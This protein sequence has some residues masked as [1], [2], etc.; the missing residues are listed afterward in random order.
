MY[1]HFVPVAWPLLAALLLIA[2]GKTAI[3]AEDAAS[4]PPMIKRP[5]MQYTADD[6]Q[7]IRQ[8][9][10]NDPAAQR[11][12][13]RTLSLSDRRGRPPQVTMFDLL[14][15]PEGADSRAAL[16]QDLRQRIGHKPEPLTWD[17]DPSTLE[18]NEG[19]PSAGDR[20]MRDERSE[21]AFLFDA[22]YDDLSAEERAG[23]EAYFRS[24]IQFHLDGHPPRHPHFQYDRTSWLPNMHWPRP[25]G[26]HLLALALQDEEAIRAM[27]HAEGGWKW[28]FDAYLVD[29]GFY[30]EE[31]G[32]QYS[33]TGSMIAW[34]EGLERLGLGEMGYDYV[35]ATG[36]SMRSHLKA[37]TQD[38]AFPATYW[39][40]G[41][42][43][44]YAR[45]TMGDAKGSGIV[46]HVVQHAVIAG[47]LADGTGGNR[48]VSAA[49][50]NGPVVKLREPYWFEA[51]HARWPE[52][53]Y[54]FFMAALRKPNE[55]MYYPSLL[56]NLD[57]I[58]P[59]TVTPPQPTPSYI[60]H[61]R[62]FA[63]LRADHS[64][65]YW[66]GPKPAVAL[67]FARYYVHYVHDCM[68]ILGFHAFNTPLIV[69]S[70]GI[71]R[72]YA[73]G[74]AWRDSVRGHSGIVVD[75]LQAQPVAR[76]FDGTQGHRYRSDFD[77]A[78]DIRFTAVR[79][80]GVYPGVAHER[81]LVLAQHYLLDV[82]WLK[83]EDPEVDRSFEWQVLSP[84]SAQISDA[85]TATD[86]LAEGALYRGSPFA[87]RMRDGSPDPTQV[88]RLDAAQQ[89]WSLR[90]AYEQAVAEGER[91]YAFGH[92]VERGV[93]M[94]IHFLGGERSTAFV[95]IPPGGRSER[96]PPTWMMVRR[97]AP[98]A[99][100]TAV[101]APFQEHQPVITEVTRLASNDHAV[102]VH[103]AGT[104][105]DGQAF[106]DVVLVAMGNH[107]E[108]EVHL[109][110]DDLSARFTGHAIIRLS[111]AQQPIAGQLHALTLQGDIIR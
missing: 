94:D 7:A 32:K 15:R 58:D 23:I 48:E 72:G 1:T 107:Y 92:F 101:Y 89:P 46:P 64:A 68:S 51:A 20:H 40:E 66:T 70:W 6:I 60:A 31:F 85:W 8:R 43:P 97:Q 56:F 63:F 22:L 79:A 90:L 102:A 93:G 65:S 45:I 14:V 37:K 75:N 35:G 106:A 108:D 44:T 98:A 73:G 54:D 4:S 29:Q 16:L 2:C 47:Y 19:M 96:A 21:D 87:D 53:K 86:E 36:I 5:F 50:M 39:G 71:G 105:S 52:D 12:A 84:A 11:Q 10:A 78:L 99:L 82:T 42:M 81:A 13:Q 3:N 110:S 26:T 104:D 111:G 28:Y 83:N 24:Y 95:G 61:Q 41:S 76:D 91:D 74:N 18:W 100:F 34:C 109:E 30:M 55:E 9:L 77:N 38:L 59:K 103:L 49:R 57:P 67:Q 25:I 80:D 27:F 33:N 17:R 88:Q 69:N 62:G